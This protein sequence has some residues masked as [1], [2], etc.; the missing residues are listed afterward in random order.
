MV[1]TT[2]KTARAS[3]R[4]AVWMLVVA[5]RRSR[6]TGTRE[7]PADP[8]ALAMPRASPRRWVILRA[9]AVVAARDRAPWPAM[10]TPANPAVRP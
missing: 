6:N 10:R 2:T 4:Q 1:T 7:I 8:T 9:T 5:R 3:S